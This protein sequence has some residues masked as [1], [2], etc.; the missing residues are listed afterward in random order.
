MFGD[1]F[2]GENYRR[3]QDSPI[4]VHGEELRGDSDK[5]LGT[6]YFEDPRDVAL[7]LSTDGFT[8]HGFTF[9]PLIIFIYNLPPTI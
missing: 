9:W 7:G 6:K 2:D 1:V 4:T 8:V 5:P 3:L